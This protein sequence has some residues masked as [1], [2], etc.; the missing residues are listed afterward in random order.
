MHVCDIQMYFLSLYDYNSIILAL[1]SNL[2][3]QYFIMKNR[4]NSDDN[5]KL[6]EKIIIIIIILMDI[7]WQE[8]NVYKLS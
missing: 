7:I 4:G 6:K 8:L 3:V 2:I 1:F 5:L